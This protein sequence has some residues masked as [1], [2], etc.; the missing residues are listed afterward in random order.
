[1]HFS[2][3]RNI[4]AYAWLQVDSLRQ[5][6][7]M[8]KRGNSCFNEQNVFEPGAI[9][10]T[11][12]PKANIIVSE[13]TSPAS[14]IGLITEAYLDKMNAD[15]IFVEIVKN[16]TPTVNETGHTPAVMNLTPIVNEVENKTSILT[17]ETAGAEHLTIT[18][19]VTEI[20]NNLGQTTTVIEVT[21]RTV[22]TTPV[23]TLT[24]VISKAT[25]IEPV[26]EINSAAEIA[27]TTPPVTSTDTTPPVTSA[28]TTPPVTSTD[29]TP[30]VTS[31][32]TTPPV[33]STDTT[34][35]VRPTSTDTTPPVTSTDTTPPVTSTDTTPPVT[36]TDTTPPVTSTD[37]TPPVTSTD[38][39]P[40]VTSTDTTPPVTS[41]DTTPPV[42]STDTT[43]PVSGTEEI[44]ADKVTKSHLMTMTIE[45]EHN[46][47]ATVFQVEPTKFAVEDNIA[48]VVNEAGST[49]DNDAAAISEA[50]SSKDDNA[51]AISEAESSKDDNAAAIS[52]A[53]SSKD[54]NAAAI[55]EAESI[56]A[57]KTITNA[58]NTTLNSLSNTV[59]ETY[60]SVDT[61]A[62]IDAVDATAVIDTVTVVDITALVHP[63]AVLSAAVTDSLTITK[64]VIEIE[65]TQFNRATIVPAH[66]LDLNT[67]QSMQQIA[68]D[69]VTTA[70]SNSSL[71]TASNISKKVNLNLHINVSETHNSKADLNEN[72]VNNQFD[73]YDI[74]DDH[75]NSANLEQL[76]QKEK[77]DIAEKQTKQ[78]L[79]NKYPVLQ[80]NQVNRQL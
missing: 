69:H 68:M 1:M 66:K 73:I 64:P 71:T 80:Q 53:E 39:T 27:D 12:Q 76:L 65:S 3:S 62:V 2:C 29:T 14:T 10:A 17:N 9:L 5:S 49:K 25:A 40:P 45:Q 8:N 20:I 54:D 51:A 31:T 4:H 22:Q 55:S 52:E 41:T 30:P 21:A 26:I 78:K 59:I 34:P 47:Y 57:V 67:H 48:E 46:V 70:S 56:K 13:A 58:T 18:N 7:A 77:T 32:D 61:S 16:A 63:I 75:A 60:A 43:P 19:G 50:E 79:A 23:G 44:M 33:T 74:N 11:Q 15:K 24:D 6:K 36:S 37:T 42:I 35:P 28:D 38:T 72:S